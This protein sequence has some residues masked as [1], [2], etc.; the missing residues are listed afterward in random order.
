MNGLLW[1]YVTERTNLVWAIKENLPEALMWNLK[2][3]GCTRVSWEYSIR[4]HSIR[5]DAENTT[6]LYL[7]N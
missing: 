3:I 4:R 7:D 2:S 6:Q 5:K 1:G